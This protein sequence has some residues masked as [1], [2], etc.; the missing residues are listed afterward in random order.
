[1]KLEVKGSTLIN[2]FTLLGLFFFT[3]M[4]N[5][6]YE[7]LFGRG[8][9]DG[10]IDSLLSDA[11]GSPLNKVVGS[12]IFCVCIFF[13][14]RSKLVFS[15][16]YFVSN[17]F[18]L[19]FMFYVMCTFFWSV[20][21]STTL[22]RVIFFSTV[23]V[24]AAYLTRYY[25]VDKI[26][27]YLGYVIGLCAFVGVI[28]AIIFPESAFVSGGLRE[29]A[30]LGIYV[31]KNGGAR[32]Y[33]LGITLLLPQ[34]LAGNRKALITA[35]LCFLCLLMAR[36]A[37]GILLVVLNLATA[38]YFNRLII[39]TNPNNNKIRYQLGF[40]FYVISI[41]VAYHLYSFIFYLVGRDATLTNRTIIWE[42]LMPLIK[43]KIE[44]GYGYGAFWNSY[45][46]DEFIAQ[47]GYIGNAHNGYLEMLLHGGL[48]MLLIFFV[49]VYYTLKKLMIKAVNV[50]SYRDYNVCIAIVFQMLISNFIAYSIPNHNSLDFFVFAIILFSANVK[51][52]RD[53]DDK[54]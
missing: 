48:P 50:S 35:M 33:V 13:Y 11:A 45:G 41:F 42:L 28:R 12:F 15:L 31:E 30:F 51:L 46:A 6:T 32:A 54:K 43:D 17:F 1:M 52:I 9:Y 53:T 22:R 47:W 7:A 3:G 38:L 39:S 4:L 24:F 23:L 40:V 19:L 18:I 21:P 16:D 5:F 26:F 2:L 37:S 44:F 14:F 20:E 8:S 25:T 27:L 36:S 10:G 29:G 34:I 49:M